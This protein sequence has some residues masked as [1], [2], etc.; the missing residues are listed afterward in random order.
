MGKENKSSLPPRPKSRQHTLRSDMEMAGV[1]NLNND[2]I[3]LD[4]NLS[5]DTVLNS[6]TMSYD[7]SSVES[8]FPITKDQ[9]G[10]QQISE[11]RDI[12]DDEERYVSYADTES[13]SSSSSF[14][15][16]LTTASLLSTHSEKSD[17]CHTLRQ[18]MQNFKSTYVHHVS[19]DISR[20][21]QHTLLQSRR[22]LRRSRG[23][24]QIRRSDH[25]RNNSPIK[26]IEKVSSDHLDCSRNNSLKKSLCFNQKHSNSNSISQD[27]NHSSVGM[28]EQTTESIES[29]YVEQRDQATS[30]E[31]SESITCR[32]N[33]EIASCKPYN[34]LRSENCDKDNLSYGKKEDDL[35]DTSNSA[36]L[37][38]SLTVD[39]QSNEVEVIDKSWGLCRFVAPDEI[40]PNVH[41]DAIQTREIDEPIIKEMKENEIFAHKAGIKFLRQGG[42]YLGMPDHHNSYSHGEDDTSRQGI[43]IF[44]LQ[45]NNNDHNKIRMHAGYLS[46]YWRGR[47]DVTP[48]L[49]RRLRDFQFA[50]KKRKQKCGNE[51]PWGILGLYDHLAAVRMD[52]E[53]A[54]DAA[55]RRANCEPYHAWS[56]FV[57]K[58]KQGYNRPFF[59]YILLIICTGSLLTSI[60]L[61]GWSIEPI[62]TNP[63]IGPSADTLVRM[64]AKET[65]LIVHQNEIWRVLSP[66]ILHAGL[67]HYFLNMLALW[68]I[69]S[70]VEQCHGFF[71][72]LIIFFIP[73]VGGTVMS[74]I[75][76]PKNISVGASGGIF[77]LIGACLA[78]IIMNW[79]ILFSDFVKKGSK[80]R[81]KFILFFLLLDVVV[82]CVIGLVPFIDNFTHL[83]GMIFGFLCGLSTMGRV[84]TGFFGPEKRGFWNTTKRNVFRYFGI[85]ISVVGIAIAS[86]F[87]LEGDGVTNPCNFC[88]VISCVPFPPWRSNDDK[89]WYCDDCYLTT[90]DIKLNPNDGSFEQLIMTCPEGS[91]ITVDLKE[92]ENKE[93]SW[94]EEN[95]SNFCRES[96]PL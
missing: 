78:D 60:A 38:E 70:A 16:T 26:F 41:H 9:F 47:D 59:T 51:R 82:N 63:M 33:S 94:L 43:D 62:S 79:N 31:R 1:I 5:S 65:Y 4:R 56:D 76:L 92:D 73:A 22:N 96:C 21:S 6:L 18:N 89:W 35:G 53:W 85:I 83:G 23:Q 66:M 77:G 12:S 45:E 64:G 25:S 84:S 14:D 91:V 72:S 37:S 7:S 69:G 17:S 42:D 90:A 48:A 61:N 27:A 24:S 28:T 8:S 10:K 88:G 86:T 29:H 55:C 20:S 44:S 50:Q 46:K 81:H 74:A 2:I 30:N 40:E 93:K 34:N 52:V 57:E 80:N 67:I 71:P 75:F 13:T 95:L 39:D 19:T 15:D 68:F 11:S 32:E 87:L 58:R 49:A 36:S 3:L 54:E